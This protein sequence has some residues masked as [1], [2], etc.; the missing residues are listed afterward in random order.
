VR[1]VVNSGGCGDVRCPR[2]YHA[3]QIARLTAW[4]LA[5]RLDPVRVGPYAR[6]AMQDADN[7]YWTLH[8]QACAD[9]AAAE[10]LPDEARQNLGDCRCRSVAKTRLAPASDRQ[11]ALDPAK[12]AAARTHPAT[13]VLASRAVA[14]AALDPW[15]PPEHRDMQRRT[16]PTSVQSA[17][18]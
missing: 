8:P 1:S 14:G 2:Q 13:E 12:K 17:T 3:P 5:A 11:R 6:R 10:R 15:P 4:A 16:W 7:P 18:R 9:A